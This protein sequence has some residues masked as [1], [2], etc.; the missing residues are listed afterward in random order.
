MMIQLA[1]LPEE[2]RAL[3]VLAE[4]G[5]ADLGG[6]S[7]ARAYYGDTAQQN[8]VLAYIHSDARK[9]AGAHV[10]QTLRTLLNRPTKTETADHDPA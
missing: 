4:A 3:L 2:A 9:A 1:L 10:L 7:A 8:D 6:N 5:L